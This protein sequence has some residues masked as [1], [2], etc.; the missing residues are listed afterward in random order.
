MMNGVVLGN[1]VRTAWKQIL[2]W[3]IGLGVLGFYIVFIASDAGIVEGYANLFESMPPALLEAFGASNLEMF[4]TTEGWIVSIFVSEA[5]IFLSAFGVLAGLNISANDERAGVM[6]VILSLP[7]SRRAYLVERW[8][9]YALIGLGIMLLSAAIT[10]I[11]VAMLAADT[12]ADKILVAILNIYPGTLLVMTV[13]CLLATILRRRAV[14]IGLAAAFVVGSYVFGI[15]GGAASGFIADL[16]EQISYFSYSQGEE[17][18]QGAYDPASTLALIV[19]ALIGF[20]LSIRMFES[21][22]VGL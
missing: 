17:I 20:A 5:A 6:D 19:V 3:G 12:P 4:R 22:D 2:Y 8:L 18:V 10:L 1:T 21:R 15:I 7:I 9:G 13:T 16:F 14:A 11:A